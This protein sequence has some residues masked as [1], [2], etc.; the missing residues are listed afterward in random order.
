M[1]GDDLIVRLKTTQ[2]FVPP[3]DAQHVI[4]TFNAMQTRITPPPG[5]TLTLNSTTVIINARPDKV[6]DDELGVGAPSSVCT[7]TK[8]L[9]AGDL[10]NCAGGG[11]LGGDCGDDC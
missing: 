10:A 7:A 1:R 9:A 11:M 8:K 2:C 3:A 4:A 5:L 6:E